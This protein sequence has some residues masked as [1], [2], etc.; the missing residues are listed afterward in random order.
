LVRETSSAP[1]IDLQAWLDSVIFNFLIGNHD[2]HGKNFS[3]LYSGEKQ[4]RLAPLYDLLSTSYYPELSPKMA[5][6][7]GGEYV[8]TKIG[9]KHFEQLAAEAGL[10]KP[11]VKRRV[12]ELAELIMSK[13]PAVT[14]NHRVSRAVAKLIQGNCER[15]AERFNV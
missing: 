3:L 12:P 2:A 14:T 7:I 11:M 9:T 4:T 15:A 5:M 6:K 8:S 13:L 1:V 10:A